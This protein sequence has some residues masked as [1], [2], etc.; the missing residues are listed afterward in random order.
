MHI[1]LVSERSFTVK[2]NGK[3]IKGMRAVDIV[4]AKKHYRRNNRRKA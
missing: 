3:E 2:A 1:E 4:T